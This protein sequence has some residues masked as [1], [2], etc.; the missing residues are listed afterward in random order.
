M[1]LVSVL[2]AELGVFIFVIYS[3]WINYHNVSYLNNTDL[4]SPCLGVRD[5]AQ[6]S[7]VPQVSH[8]LHQVVDEAGVSS[9]SLTGEGSTFKLIQIVDRIFFS[10]GCWAKS[11]RFLL[12]VGQAHSHFLAT[13]AS[14]TCPLLQQSMR[15]KR[16]YKEKLLARQK[17]QSLVT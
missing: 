1:G 9:E 15:A 17:L 8:R 3:C 11:L 12:V 2:T 7:P 16:A 4:L 5:P 10:R 6:L 14:P 13:W